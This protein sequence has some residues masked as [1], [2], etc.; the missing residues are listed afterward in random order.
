[1]INIKKELLLKYGDSIV[2]TVSSDL[3][4]FKDFYAIYADINKQGENKMPC[5]C[6]PII[7][8][9]I[10]LICRDKQMLEE[11]QLTSDERKAIYCHEMGHVYS[12]NQK[13][14][15][16]ERNYADEIDI[17]TFAIEKCDISIDVLE[18]ALKKTYEYDIKRIKNG[19][20]KDKAKIKRYIDEMTARKRNI[21]RLRERQKEQNEL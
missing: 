6:I 13:N 2:A 4:K 18:S 16:K 10:T 15:T 1:M 19:Q 7:D 3:M 14:R 5:F 12:P 21:E 17:D 11:M 20:Q 9:K 8:G